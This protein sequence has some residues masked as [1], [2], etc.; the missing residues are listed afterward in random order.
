MLSNNTSSV[1]DRV[2]NADSELFDLSGGYFVGPY[3]NSTC[4]GSESLFIVSA[5][6]LATGDIEI[7]SSA[8]TTISMPYLAQ[9]NG[10]IS[11]HDNLPLLVLKSSIVNASGFISVKENPNLIE[12]DLKSLGFAQGIYIVSNARLSRLRLDSLVTTTDVQVSMNAVLSRLE[13]PSLAQVSGSF[14]VYSNQAL[15]F[16]SLPLFNSSI[17][18]S[19][20]CQNAPSLILPPILSLSA[21]NTT[22]R[23]NG[24]TTCGRVCNGTETLQTIQ[25]CSKLTTTFPSGVASIISAPFMTSVS[26][27]VSILSNAVLAFIN[28]PTLTYIDGNLLI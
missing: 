16:L 10:N 19:F 20:I 4:A 23:Q 24:N 12:V 22:I 21:T 6:V 13:L 15:T 28:L 5:C 25:T 14:D 8:L 17:P 3:S 9:S 26:G 7:N 2:R 11:V 1:L 18:S 27:P